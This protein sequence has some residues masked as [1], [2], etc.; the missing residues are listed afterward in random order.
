V[1]ERGAFLEKLAL[2]FV[3]WV[4]LVISGNQTF[5]EKKNPS[6]IVL[7]LV[8]RRILITVLNNL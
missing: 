6:I 7:V 5:E 3:L 8:N 1:L 2:G 4:L